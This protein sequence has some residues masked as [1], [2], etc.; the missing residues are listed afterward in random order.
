MM[1][2]MRRRTNTFVAVVL[3]VGLIADSSMAIGVRARVGD[4]TKVKGQRTN[5]LIGMGSGHRA[6]TVRVTEMS[7]FPACDRSLRP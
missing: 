6:L 3:L 4:V 5:K 1:G 2:I 7:I